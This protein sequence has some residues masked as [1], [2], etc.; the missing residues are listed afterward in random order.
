MHRLTV[1]KIEKIIKFDYKYIDSDVSTLN[2]SRAC[3]V[4]PLNFFS[5]S[6]AKRK[7]FSKSWAIGN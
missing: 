5:W 1:E 3:D 4:T 2:A 6:Y 7:Q